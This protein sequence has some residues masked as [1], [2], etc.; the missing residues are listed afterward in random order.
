MLKEIH[1]G[2]PAMSVP[3]WTLKGVSLTKKEASLLQAWGCP[4]EVSASQ[5]RKLEQNR[6]YHA[7]FDGYNISHNIIKCNMLISYLVSS[8][9]IFETPGIIM[10]KY[11]G[12]SWTNAS[13]FMPST[14]WRRLQASMRANVLEAQQLHVWQRRS[15]LQSFSIS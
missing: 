11:S 8:G 7:Y 10:D 5:P 1:C 3:S 13:G 9:F 12:A 14:L 15:M 2:Q 6:L 4:R